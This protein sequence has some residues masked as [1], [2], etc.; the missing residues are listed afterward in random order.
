MMVSVD[1][2]LTSPAAGIVQ[3]FN[4]AWNARQVDAVIDLI[5]EDCVF[6]NTSPFPDGERFEGKEAVRAVWE[7]VMSTP[8]MLFETEEVIS[9]G[10]RVVTRWRYNWTDEAG[11]PGHIRGVD[12]FKLRDGK[13]AEKL[14]YV[15]G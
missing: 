8:G 2:P 4:D 6:E 11:A 9:F 10:D 5:T 12:I 7:A 3:Q 1:T 13:I 14:S 15:K